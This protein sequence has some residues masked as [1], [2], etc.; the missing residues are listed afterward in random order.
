MSGTDPQSQ[1]LYERVCESYHAVDDFRM[2]L[3]GLLPIATGTAVFLLLNGNADL[4]GADDPGHAGRAGST[5]AEASNALL[6]IGLF[7]LVFTVGLF[8]YELFGIKKC[9]YLIAT[10]RRLEDLLGAEGQFRSRP[11]NL[12]G[13]VNEPYA[14]AVIYPACMA[15]WAFLALVSQSPAAAATVAAV[16]FVAGYVLTVVGSRRMADNQQREQAVLDFIDPGQ[17]LEMEGLRHTADQWE[18][19]HRRPPPP[20]SAA[21]RWQGV[22]RRIAG[23]A[24]GLSAPWR[25][26][27]DDWVDV[28]VGRLHARGVLDLDSGGAT[29]ER[30][31][32]EPQE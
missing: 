29:V 12:A 31:L 28:V 25:S 10:G 2:K 18:L 11:Q 6:A 13:F 14:S 23:V 1:V 17:T 15:A 16:L 30:P 26:R 9:H 27:H 19:R 22:K 8:A 21:Q 24:D 3:L 32:G 7:G 5:V 4:L 20:R